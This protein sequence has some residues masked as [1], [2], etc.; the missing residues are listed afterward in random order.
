MKKII[1]FLSLMVILL[2]GTALSYFIDDFDGNSLSSY[3]TVINEDNTS[4][5]V[6]DGYLYT[7]TNAGDLWG[8]YNDYITQVS[9]P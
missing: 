4:Y 2:P 6:S 7:K 3:W 8:S 1:I 9:H 5:S